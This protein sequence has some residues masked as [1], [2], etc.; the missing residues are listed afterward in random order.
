MAEFSEIEKDRR[1]LK[2]AYSIEKLDLE[3]YII[4]FS[5][6]YSKSTQIKLSQ[7]IKLIMIP[8]RDV[9]PSNIL[10]K[11]IRTLFQLKT[12]LR[13]C[14]KIFI[15]KNIDIYHS[16]NALTLPIM[17]LK[18]ILTK[19]PLIYDVHEVWWELKD[20]FINPEEYLEKM[21]IKFSNYIITYSEKFNP[22]I[23][24]KYHLNQKIISLSNYPSLTELKHVT[25]TFDVIE[26]SKFPI[27]R[28]LKIVYAGRINPN[29]SGLI[30]FFKLMS[31]NKKIEFHIYGF[32]SQGSFDIIN[33][34]IKNYQIEDQVFLHNPV[35]SQD[36]I[37][38]LKLYDVGIILYKKGEK[39]VNYKTFSSNKLYMY[40][41]AGLP[42]ICSKVESYFID[43]NKYDVMYWVEWDITDSLKK[44][45]NNLF[46]ENRESFLSR[47]NRCLLA[48]KKM[49]WEYEESGL[50][51]IYSE[52]IFG[53]R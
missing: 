3:I 30:S 10:K 14:L 6:K 15:I 22:I 43:F 26:E 52:L 12:I 44:T 21:F 45:L 24:T 11:I 41:H 51:K 38:F 2:E 13:I 8:H 39:I 53:N 20:Q 34:I 29:N 37:K 35:P 7:N 1:I 33:E 32:K 48:S 16:H 4:G 5:K 28:K 9:I 40:L 49:I 23:K 31:D 46:N 27:N 17:S 19:K 25:K 42:V 47:K 36:L 18:S 50:H